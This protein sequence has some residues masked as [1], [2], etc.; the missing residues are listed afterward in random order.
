MA[1]DHGTQDDAVAEDAAAA[2]SRSP[3]AFNFFQAVRR[4][5]CRHK[6]L[7]RVGY[8]KVPSDDPVRFCQE[9]AMSFPPADVH[10]FN[11]HRLSD[12]PPRLTVYF[13]GLLGLNGPMPTHF[14][15]LV[16]DRRSRG[17]KGML[18]FVDLFHHRMISFFYRAWADHQRVNSFDRPGED[19]IGN[20]VASLFGVGMEEL[21]QRDSVPDVAKLHFA[22]RLACPTRNAEGLAA[23]LQRYFT[24]PVQIQQFVGHW[25]DVPGENKWYLGRS[26]QTGALGHNMVLGSRTWDVQQK[27]QI[28]MGPMDFK[29]YQRMFPDRSSVERLKAWVKNYVGLELAWD[30]QMIV[31]ASEVPRLQLGKVGHLGWS[32]W[33]LHKKSSRDRGDLMVKGAA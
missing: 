33:L 31:K 11:A 25:I 13:M 7:P 28:C 14:T 19:P 27:F 5:E 9:P 26:R 2:L 32:S 18:R 15:R 6:H 8:S 21:R 24:V 23:I 20:Y 10:S 22:G 3:W 17:D 29:T 4:I 30:A 16:R 12:L 1:G